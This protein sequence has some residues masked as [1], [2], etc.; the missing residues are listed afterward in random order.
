MISGISTPGLIRPSECDKVSMETVS[1]E[2]TVSLGV[3]F[4]SYQP[5]C[6][7]SAVAGRK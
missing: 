3:S 5:H 2:R 4:G 6:T 7:F 1:P